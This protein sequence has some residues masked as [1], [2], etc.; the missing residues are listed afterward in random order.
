M[1]FELYSLIC[2]KCGARNS[3]LLRNCAKCGGSVRQLRR[4]TNCQTENPPNAYV[5]LHCYRVLKSKLQT[6]FIHFYIPWPVSFLVLFISLGWVSYNFLKG[7]VE[8]VSAQMELRTQE[9][10]NNT[11]QRRG[12]MARKADRRKESYANQM[13]EF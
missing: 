8:L 6:K 3:P 10:L 9:E 2:Q 11:F 4:C 13:D 5:C 7:W 12:L 1:R